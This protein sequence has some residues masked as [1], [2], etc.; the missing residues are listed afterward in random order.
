MPLRGPPPTGWPDT[1]IGLQARTRPEGAVV[2]GTWKMRLSGIV[3]ALTLAAGASVYVAA[4]AP[5][6][7]AAGLL[8]QHHGDSRAIESV[9]NPVPFGQRVK[10]TA[11]V[12]LFPLGGLLIVPSGKVSFSFVSNGIT[13]SLGSPSPRTAG[14]QGEGGAPWQPP[15]P[16]RR[17]RRRAGPVRRRSGDLRSGRPRPDMVQLRRPLAPGHDR[18]AG[19]DLRPRPGRGRL[20]LPDV[21]CP[22]GI[23]RARLRRRRVRRRRRRAAR[24]R[25]GRGHRRRPARP[26]APWP[27][28]AG[29]RSSPSSTAR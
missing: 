21:P 14:T 9:A 5:S 13:V 3:G 15:E 7:G 24:R 19:G 4:S 26:P 22:V 28:Q 29:G 23:R 10:L 12:S 17:L 8:H 6:A 25:A 11:D 16:Q 27:V 1:L 18:I 2:M 20:R